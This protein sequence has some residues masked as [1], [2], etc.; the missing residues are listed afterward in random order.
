MAMQRRDFMALAG[1]AVLMLPLAARAQQAAMPVIGF[2]HISSAAPFTRFLAAFKAGLKE[3]GYVE[4][5]NVA[6][7]YRWAEA[8][9][10]RLPAL[11]ADLVRRGVTVIA[12]A[13]GEQPALAA[14]AASKTIPVLFV[15]GGDPVKLG[16]VP[17]LARPAGHVTGITMLTLSL[18]NKRFGLLREMIPNART[19]A[20]LIDPSRPV[21]RNQ[22]EQMRAAATQVG[23]KLVIVQASNEADIDAAFSQIAAQ[24]AGALLIGASPFF[25]SRRQQIVTLAAHHRLPTMYEWRDITEAGGLMSYGTDLADAYRQVGLYTAKVLKGA[26]P[27]D[28]PVLQATKFEFV[29][30]LV[31]AKALGLEISPT[32]LARADAVIE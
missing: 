13:G 10:D 8:Q 15:M 9:G 4:G 6:I 21:A 19:I 14:K 20:A 12:T 7:E 31:T 1:G 25:L 17:S 30:N 18:E 27:A 2:L 29:I 24:G 23:V 5:E 3:G 32:V 22:I 16:V 28:L 26:K 11:A